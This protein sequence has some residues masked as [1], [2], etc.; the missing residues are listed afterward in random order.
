M[1]QLNDRSTV[2]H[3]LV[4]VTC[5][6]AFMVAAN[7]AVNAKPW[8][9]KNGRVAESGVLQRPGAP[10]TLELIAQSRARKGVRAIQTALVVLGY[11]PGP[12]D[13]LFGPQTRRSVELFQRV[14]GL[15]V[16]GRVGPCTQAAL[17]RLV[18]RAKRT[19]GDNFSAG[20][21]S[22]ID[23]KTKSEVSTYILT[24][25]GVLVPLVAENGSYYGEIS[26]QTGRPK[27]VHVRGYFRKDG[28]Y[29]RGHYRS[30]PRHRW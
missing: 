20:F 7:G 24:Y 17:G 12:V 10:P 6:L 13:G 9:D 23:W 22:S 25:K 26:T 11:H 14:H 30:R 2:R 27:T 5:I 4:A 1:V 21:P 15:E 29:V 28:T 19:V 3:I 18:L 8:I 16:D